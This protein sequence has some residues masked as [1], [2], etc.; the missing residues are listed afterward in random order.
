MKFIDLRFET[1]QVLGFEK[2][3][4]RIDLNSKTVRLENALKLSPSQGC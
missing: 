3:R 1:W 2:A 4:R